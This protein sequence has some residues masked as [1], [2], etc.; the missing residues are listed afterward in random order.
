MFRHLFATSDDPAALVAR[1]ALGVVILPHG[2]QKTLGWF[3]GAGLSGT[4]QFFT[5]NLGIPALLALLAIAAESLGALALVAGF[6]TRAAALGV[7]VTMA[8]AAALVHLDHGFF[9]NWH[10]S[11]AARVSSSTSSPSASPLCC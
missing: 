2:L 4:L 1:L 6:A 11:Q 8:V 9:M 7:G 3:G 5:D 10:G